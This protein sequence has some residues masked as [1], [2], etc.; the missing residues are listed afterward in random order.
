MRSQLPAALNPALKLFQIH[1]NAAIRCFSPDTAL[2]P[3]AVL[4][5]VAH[6]V[7]TISSDLCQ[8]VDQYPSTWVAHVLLHGCASSAR[9]ET[10]IGNIISVDIVSPT[11]VFE[12]PLGRAWAYA[13]RGWQLRI[14]IQAKLVFGG[15]VECLSASDSMRV[16]VVML[17]LLSRPIF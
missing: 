12:N 8:S 16:L 15:R 17:A 5:L 7:F 9:I 13:G 10:D 3:S 4:D 14:H 1:K 11:S 2:R 6:R